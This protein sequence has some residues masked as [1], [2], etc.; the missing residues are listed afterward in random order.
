MDL[1]HGARF[2][3]H[4]KHGAIIS[5]AEACSFSACKTGTKPVTGMVQKL[6]KSRAFPAQLISEHP[7]LE[8]EIVDRRQFLGRQHDL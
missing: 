5:R 8:P 6:R 4:L 2:V 7:V 1:D 3:M